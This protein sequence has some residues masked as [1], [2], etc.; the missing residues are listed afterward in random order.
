VGFGISVPVLSVVSGVAN[1]PQRTVD[2]SAPCVHLEAVSTE[3]EASRR[4]L[5][6]VACKTG[7]VGYLEVVLLL[8]VQFLK[9]PYHAEHSNL[10]API[11][12]I[13][14]AAIIGLLL[15]PMLRVSRHHA[16]VSFRG[17]RL[18]RRRRRDSAA[19][20]LR[21]R[22]LMGELCPHG[23]SC[24][25]TLY[26]G[27]LPPDEE[28]P[29]DRIALDWVELHQQAGRPAVMRR[30]WAGSIAEALEAMVADRRTDLALEQIE[31]RA[32]LEGADWP[33]A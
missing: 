2:R 32:T 21:A 18:R 26:E 13:F 5:G 19:V 20:E 23:W 33:D 29:P 3:D 12:M 27:P 9:R 25:I 31:L 8:W 10:L 22:A 30:V 28:P 11:A 7:G 1:W 16:L 15:I 14:V 6:E 4:D 17:W 24:Q